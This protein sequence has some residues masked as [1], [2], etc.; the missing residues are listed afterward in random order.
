MKLELTCVDPQKP[1]IELRQFPVI[2]GLDP[3]SDVCLDD[4]SVGHYQC[5]IDQGDGGLMVWDLGTKLGTTIN[6]A[7]VRQKAPLRPGDELGIGKHRFVAHYEDGAATPARPQTHTGSRPATP[8]H[9]RR[10]AAQV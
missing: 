10:Q 5:M 8:A 1:S 6:G 9:R 4:S 2:F 3:G 7:R